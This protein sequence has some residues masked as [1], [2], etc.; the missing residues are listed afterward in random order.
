MANVVVKKVS[1]FDERKNLVVG[2]LSDG[3]L[4]TS[5]VA[6]YS[7]TTG[8]DLGAYDFYPDQNMVGLILTAG[9]GV[10]PLVLKTGEMTI[11]H[12]VATGTVEVFMKGVIITKI[13]TTGYTYS[14]YIFPLF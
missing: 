5:G 3:Q 4:N 12:T 2:T 11:T 7:K 6:I 10:I 13:L 1:L 9:T 8:I 14:G